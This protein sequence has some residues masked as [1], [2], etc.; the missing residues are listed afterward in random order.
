M[1]T[2]RIAVALAALLIGV[3]QAMAQEFIL[4]GTV[5]DPQGEP[6]TGATVQVVNTS[7]AVATDI[8]GNFA[9]GVN[10]GQH[11]KIN[12]VGFKPADITANPADN[13][14]KVTLE[15]DVAK[16]EE[17]VVI[18]YGSVHKKD[19]TGAVV[20]VNPAKLADQNPGT[21][22]DLLRGT[23]GLQVGYDTSA[24][25]GGSLLIRGVNSVGTSSSPLIILDG[26]IFYGELSEINPDDIA[27]ID[28]LKDASA[29]AVYG[30]S[31]AGGVILITTNKGK[32]GKPVITVSGNWGFSRR[33]GFRKVYGPD[34]WMANREVYY[35]DQTY[36]VNPETGAYE[37]YQ[38][39]DKNGKLV[40]PTGYFD[41][42]D[43]I[44]KYGIDLDTWLGYTTN[45]DMTPEEV[46][47][48]RLN[49]H[50]AEGALANYL[51]GRTYDW[52]SDGFRTGFNQDYNASVSGATE[53]ADYYVSFGYLKN[54]G[55]VRG[56]DY[57]AA[58]VSMKI[59]TEVT[60]W[61]RI[62]AQA[63]F[64]DRSDDSNPAD[65]GDAGKQW[66]PRDAPR[67]RVCS[68][69]TSSA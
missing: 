47:A 8:D 25:G 59:N 41:H 38:L 64:Q 42:F 14:L 50:E 3:V 30:A 34:N 39:R 20:Q 65:W 32:M 35:K 17:V 18:G 5:S 11:V 6:L 23:A 62:G 9:I 63:N 27:Q 26:M 57:H 22:A 37:Y 21:V 12:Y 31:A 46:Y 16:L 48:R 36:G 60:P 58:R 67:P 15:E 40:Y 53:R 51:A 29:A 2:R 44:G 45:T 33:T 52:A 19:L 49:L 13:P 28:V 68:T 69:A 7:K 43:N 56:D 4:K 1:S 66:V 54:E 24:K 61:L 55:V 10:P